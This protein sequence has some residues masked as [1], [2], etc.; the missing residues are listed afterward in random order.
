MQFRNPFTIRRKLDDHA[1]TPYTDDLVQLLAARFGTQAGEQGAYVGAASTKLAELFLQHGHKLVATASRPEGRTEFEALQ[2]R[3]PQFKVVDG[4]PEATGLP[5]QS[6]D[7]ILSERVLHLANLASIR[8]EFR[9]ILRPGGVV[10]LITDNRVYAGSAQAEAFEEL[11]RTHCRNFKEKSAPSD[12]AGKVATFYNGGEVFEDAFIGRQ[13]L[14]LRA[15]I[16]QTR[17]MAIFPKVG[18]AQ[19][20]AIHVALETFF[21]TWAVDGLLSVPIVCRVA[22]GRIGGAGDVQEHIQ[23]ELVAAGQ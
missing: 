23:P 14:T 6:I 18:D 2:K 19:H 10:M 5:S 13:M 20:D 17:C 12:I 7:F 9:R 4:T 21:A 16:D 15:L 11:L 1:T 22:C 3:F 8:R